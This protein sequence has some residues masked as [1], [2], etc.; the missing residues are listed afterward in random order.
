MCESVD[1]CGWS[2]ER[3]A[4]LF[5]QGYDVNPLKMESKRANWRGCRGSEDI[6]FLTHTYIH[7]YILLRK[8]DYVIEKK[9]G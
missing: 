5:L 8:L 9:K 4:S 3:D 6:K 7:T 2:R 1:L